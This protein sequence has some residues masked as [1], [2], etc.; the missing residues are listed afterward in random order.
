LDLHHPSQFILSL[1]SQK[2]HLEDGIGVVL[3]YEVAL[4]DEESVSLNFQ[5]EVGV[6]GQ[7]WS[8]R[9]CVKYVSVHA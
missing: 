7:G 9:C 5:V 1:S 8:C 3:G 6:Q 2:Q 4:E